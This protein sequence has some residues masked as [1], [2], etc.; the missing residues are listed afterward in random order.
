VAQGSPARGG[1][2]GT[3]GQKKRDADEA[4][5]FFFFYSISSEYQVQGKSMPTIFLI[6][7]VEVVCFVHLLLWSFG[8]PLD[9]FSTFGE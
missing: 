8:R 3:P 5:L 4:S 1:V 2:F 7:G 9:K 6:F